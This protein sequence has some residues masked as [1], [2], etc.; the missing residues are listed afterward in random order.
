MIG[1]YPQLP[2]MGTY[3][4]LV[5]SGHIGIYIPSKDNVAPERVEN[6]SPEIPNQ[7]GLSVKVSLRRFGPQ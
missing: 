2:V 1:L 3:L 6:L 4:Y 5:R 7:C